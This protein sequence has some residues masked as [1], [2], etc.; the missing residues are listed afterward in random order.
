MFARTGLMMMKKRRWASLALLVVAL[1]PVAATA[2]ADRMYSIADLGTLPGTTSSVAKSINN[3]GQ[4]VGVSY[5][6]ET[7]DHGQI[8][9][10]SSAQSFQSHGGSL[11]QIQPVGGLAT[12]INDSGQSVGG[13]YSAI[14][15]R[16]QYV[17]VN[18][19]YDGSSS[20]SIDSF[21]PTAIN[22]NG[23]IAGNRFILEP[24]GFAPRPFLLD[25]GLM[26]DISPQPHNVFN[27]IVALNDRGEAVLNT[28]D[29]NL[30]WHS[31]VIRYGAGMIGK[32]IDETPPNYSADQHYFSVAGYPKGYFQNIGLLPGG[33]NRLSH[34]INNLGQVVGDGFLL[35]NGVIKELKDLLPTTSKWTGLDAYSI[36]DSGQIVGRGLI[37]GAEHAFLIT[38]QPVP[39]PSTLLVFLPIGVL[40]LRIRRR[41]FSSR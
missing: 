39:E 11:R 1:G 10:D 36:N 30:K 28:R 29:A 20:T 34:A 24:Y 7:N 16:G 8:G 12:S 23:L 3:S 4:V 15:N 26:L 9:Y 17:D 31:Y 38:P 41:R 18:H 27:Q 2:R 14:N 37:D 13:P 6:T 21:V 40:I 33:D 25:K 5:N 19:I 32:L 22:N 35:D